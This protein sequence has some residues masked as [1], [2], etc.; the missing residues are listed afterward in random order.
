M[1]ETEKYSCTFVWREQISHIATW[2]TTLLHT[3]AETK[4]I[5]LSMQ[6]CGHMI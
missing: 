6:T 3:Y 1:G 2:K 5:Y 4:L